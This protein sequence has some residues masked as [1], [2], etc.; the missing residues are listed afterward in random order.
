LPSDCAIFRAHASL[1]LLQSVSWPF[2]DELPAQACS[3]P[4]TPSLLAPPYPT[5]PT[6][7]PSSQLDKKINVG[8]KNKCF[9]LQTHL[10]SGAVL[11]LAKTANAPSTFHAEGPAIGSALSS[12]DTD[13][14]PKC[15]HCKLLHRHLCLNKRTFSL[16]VTGAVDLS[17]DAALVPTSAAA[18]P[19]ADPSAPSYQGCSLLESPR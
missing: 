15:Q 19:I 17:T 2:L 11:H 13:G 6:R 5:N 16:L 14:L 8:Q 7:L 4:L 12:A 1:E 18:D 10:I 9:F 3:W